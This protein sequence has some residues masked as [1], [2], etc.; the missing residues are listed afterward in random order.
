MKKGYMKIYI[1]IFFTILILITMIL[2]IAYFFKNQYDNEQFK[3]IKTDMMLIEAKTEAIAQRMKMKEK[4]VTYIGKKIEEQEEREEIKNLQ[5]KNIINL[6]EKNNKYYILEKEHL[7]K[8]GLTTINIKKGYYIVE[9]DKNEII[10]TRG[11]ND[12][13]GNVIYTLSE[14]EKI[15]K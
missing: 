7:E 13:N 11:I 15:K 14:L 8:L 10:Y 12:N 1:R 5:N 3:T 9:Y 2:G 6:E 4:G